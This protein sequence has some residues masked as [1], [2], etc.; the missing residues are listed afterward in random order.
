MNLLHV[1]PLVLIVV[2]LIAAQAYKLFAKKSVS[3]NFFSSFLLILCSIGI[4]SGNNVHH[5]ELF[6]FFD[7]CFGYAATSLGV[8]V[9]LVKSKV[10]VKA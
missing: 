4:I 1:G 5:G 3:A 8:A 9:N 6:S 7:P 10:R 2:S